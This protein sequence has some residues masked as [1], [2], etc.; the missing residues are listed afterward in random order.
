ME[1]RH[2]HASDQFISGWREHGFPLLERIFDAVRAETNNP[3]FAAAV[4]AWANCGPASVIQSAEDATMHR[5]LCEFLERCATVEVCA[6]YERWQQKLKNCDL[7]EKLALAFLTYRFQL[8]RHSRTEPD[9][10]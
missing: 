10:A 1:G 9:P 7:S 5:E 4:T 3:G 8:T 2:I 6:V